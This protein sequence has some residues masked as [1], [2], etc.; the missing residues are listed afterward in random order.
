MKTKNAYHNFRVLNFTIEG[1]YAQQSEK[2]KGPLGI[3]MLRK[4][5]KKTN[6]KKF[7]SIDHRVYLL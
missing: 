4:A 3:H 6:Q 7:I 1:L 5:H 2:C